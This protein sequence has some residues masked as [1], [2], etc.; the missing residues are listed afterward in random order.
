M[1]ELLLVFWERFEVIPNY[2]NVYRIDKIK[3]VIWISRKL[4]FNWIVYDVLLIT[5]EFKK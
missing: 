4:S 3:R 2:D 5:Y 1:I